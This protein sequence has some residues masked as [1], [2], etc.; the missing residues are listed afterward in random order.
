M[1]IPVL[2]NGKTSFQLHTLPSKSPVSATTV[3]NF[4]NCSN[5]DA[6]LGFFGSEWSDIM[7]IFGFIS[8]NLVLPKV[9]AALAI[10][11]LK[12]EAR[13]ELE[14]NIHYLMVR[15]HVSAG[16]I[17]FPVFNLVS[18]REWSK[19]LSFFT[20]LL[21][22]REEKPTFVVSGRWQQTLCISM[23]SRLGLPWRKTGRVQCES[24]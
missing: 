14:M 24:Y 12:Q 20:W 19:G 10:N 5:V 13:F 1:H 3:V 11:A 8:M 16:L 21:L 7:H 23:R 9:G 22:W 6:I 2:R 15:K 18:N 4:F 17:I